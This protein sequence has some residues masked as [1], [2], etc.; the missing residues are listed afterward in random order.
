MV[1]FVEYECFENT[2]DISDSDGMHITLSFNDEGVLRGDV[3]FDQYG[4]SDLDVRLTLISDDQVKVEARICCIVMNN[5]ELQTA[6]AQIVRN[7]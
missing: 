1:V 2:V 5:S 4:E 6:L 7:S 3:R